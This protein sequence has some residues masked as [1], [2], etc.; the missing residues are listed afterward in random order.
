M[1]NA[2]LEAMAT[3]LPVVMTKFIGLSDDFGSPGNEYI[4]VGRT[5][6]ELRIAI[7]NIVNDREVTALLGKNAREWILQTMNTESSVKAHAEV[8]RNLVSN[9]SC[10]VRH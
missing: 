7:N 6:A 9:L 1:P 4:L 2:V 3:G 10:R 8:Y 5:S